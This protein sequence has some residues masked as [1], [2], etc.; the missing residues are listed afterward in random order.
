MRLRVHHRTEY[1]YFSPV[2]D[3][4]NELHLKPLQTRWQTCESAIISVLPAVRLTSYEDLHQ[5]TVHHFEVPEK[6]DRLVID[7][8]CTVTTASKVDF[9]ALP[10]G[11]PHSGLRALK[12]DEECFPFLQESRYVEINPEHWRLALDIQD[13]ST[14]VFQTA[15][16]IMEY[17][18]K[19]F[20]YRYGSTTV[21]THASE[22]ISRRCGVCQDFAHAMVTLC[23]CLGI[24]C[25]YVSGYFFDATRH[26]TLRGSEASHAWAEVFIPGHGWIGLD[27]TNNKVVDAT[28]I[29]IAIGRD[30]R[31]VTPVSGTYFGSGS[32]MLEVKVTVE[33]LDFPAPKATTPPPTAK[34]VP[35]EVAALKV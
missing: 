1:R 32:S 19:N 17:I 10:Y 6:H 11:F 13:F 2:W 21:S 22:V 5:N 12:G 4:Q 26:H 7:S 16:A 15:Y 23:R 27:P 30:Y 33:R 20:E 35:G 3:S 24:P 14:D 18:F 9:E 31:D 8:R 25:R 29:A 28:Y 34:P